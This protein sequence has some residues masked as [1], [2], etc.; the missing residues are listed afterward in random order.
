MDLSS[1]IN[2]DTAECVIVDP[3]TGKNTDIVITVYA[4][5]T[6]DSKSARAKAG[7]I[8]DVDNFANYLA[9]V[10]ISWVNVEFEGKPLKCNRKNAL[11]I[12]NHKGQ[13]VAMQIANFLGA[14]DSFL[15]KR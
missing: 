13:I 9:D 15:P 5:H 14:Q 7:D 4:N 6:A 3:R 1:L 10:T 8:A 12:Y 2:N 11:D